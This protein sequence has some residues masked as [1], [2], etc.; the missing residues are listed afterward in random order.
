MNEFLYVLKSRHIEAVKVGIT[1]DPDARMRQLKVG[2]QADLLCIVTVANS[3][4]HETKIHKQLESK[5]LPQSE[6][7]ALNP[8]EES[9]LLNNVMGLGP[10]MACLPLRKSTKRKIEA[11]A[12]K[13]KTPAVNKLNFPVTKP[14]SAKELDAQYKFKNTYDEFFIDRLKATNPWIDG[15][16]CSYPTETPDINGGPGIHVWFS[17]PEKFR[18][19]SHVYFHP[20]DGL[21][22]LHNSYGE[23]MQ[24]LSHPPRTF[25]EMICLLEGLKDLPID[26]WPLDVVMRHKLLELGDAKIAAHWGMSETYLA[27]RPWTQKKDNPDYLQLY[28]WTPR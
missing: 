20:G 23:F 8:D 10:L 16:T 15:I 6:W 17:E 9:A 24:T 11:K 18:G 4:D 3:R 5:H 27:F 25:D 13:P 7:F 12:S 26:Q 19:E 14:L 21:G 22:E 2:K 28:P 1:A